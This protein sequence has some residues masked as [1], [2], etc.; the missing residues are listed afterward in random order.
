MAKDRSWKEYAAWI[1]GGMAL[2]SHCGNTVEN[3]SASGKGTVVAG[4]G[5]AAGEAPP[6]TAAARSA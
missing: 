5:A 1:I 6:A 4:A 2:L 3:M